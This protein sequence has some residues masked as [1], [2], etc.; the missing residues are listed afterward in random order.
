MPRQECASLKM[1]GELMKADS[2]APVASMFPHLRVLFSGSVEAGH[3]IHSANPGRTAIP[4]LSKQAGDFSV[5]SEQP[6]ER[7]PLN[8]ALQRKS[9]HPLAA[10]WI[11]GRS[12]YPQC[13][14]SQRVIE[15]SKGR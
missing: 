1:Q 7:R 5:L 2:A 9:L 14:A 4:S 8:R 11:E 6:S 3:S 13:E 10:R 12:S 15:M